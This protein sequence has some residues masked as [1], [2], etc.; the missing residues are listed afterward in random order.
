MNFYHYSGTSFPVANVVALFVIVGIII[1]IITIVVRDYYYRPIAL[2]RIESIWDMFNDVEGNTYIYDDFGKRFS[3]LELYNEALQKIRFYRI[4]PEAIGCESLHLF[5]RA[6]CNRLEREISSLT[7]NFQERL[8][9]LSENATRTR[10]VLREEYDELI[11][12]L[13]KDLLELKADAL[14]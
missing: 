13:E 5:H 9:G 11:N 4:D 6:A 12:S 14:L 2:H 8:R 3:V 1:A 7:S 10:E